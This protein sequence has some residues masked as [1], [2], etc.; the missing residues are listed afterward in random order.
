MVS[1]NDDG[2]ERNL[3]ACHVRVERDEIFVQAGGI[4]HTF[5]LS[6]L[7]HILDVT[8]ASNDCGAANVLPTGQC[9]H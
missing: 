7:M 3:V 8:L 1:V 2:Q 6:K 4:I 9:M 5:L